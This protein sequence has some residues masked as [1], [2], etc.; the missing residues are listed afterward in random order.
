MAIK[1]KSLATYRLVLVG[2]STPNGC[3][4]FVNFVAL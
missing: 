3:G 4:K 2:F 1:E